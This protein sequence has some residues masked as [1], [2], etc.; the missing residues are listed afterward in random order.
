MRTTATSRFLFLVGLLCA[1]CPGPDFTPV[2]FPSAETGSR[3][4]APSESPR[5]V[6]CTVQFDARLCVAIKGE[7]V[8]VGTD[9]KDPL[10][11]DGLPP[12]PIEIDGGAVTIRG[13]RFPDLTIE[14]HGLPAPITINGRGDTSGSDNIGAGIIS[15]DGTIA[16]E[17]FS[18]FVMALGHSGKIPDLTLTTG[19][20]GPLGALPAVTGA[21][22]DSAGNLGLVTGTILGSLFPGADEV[23]K[24]AALTASFSGTVAPALSAC[25]ETGQ[26]AIFDATKLVVDQSGKEVG[27][28]LPGGNRLEVSAGTYIATEPTDV[29]PRFEATAKFRVVNN[30]DAPVPVQLTS[31]VGPFNIEAIG[32][33]NQTV[34]PNGE[35]IF[36]IR[37][38]PDQETVKKAGE[39]EQPLRIGPD[40]FLL[41]GTAIEPQGHP[42]IDWLAAD[43]SLVRENVDQVAVGE[44]IVAATTQHAYFQCAVALCGG[45][46]LPASCK[47]CADHAGGACQL[48]AVGAGGIPVDEVTPGCQPANPNEREQ[49]LINFGGDGVEPLVPTTQLLAIRNTGPKPLTVTQLVLKEAARSHSKGQFVFDPGRIFVGDRFDPAAVTNDSGAAQPQSAFPLVL[50]PFEPPFSATQLFV[51]VGYAPTDLV[52][53]EG[54]TAG[55]G[56]SVVDFAELNIITDGGNVSVKCKGTTRIKDMPPLQAVF[57]TATGPK[58][59]AD[60]QAFPFRG[61]TAATTDLPIP[62]FLRIPEGASPLRIIGIQIIGPDGAHFEWLDAKEE[63]LAKPEAARCT[64]LIPVSLAPNGYD[65]KP[66]AHT[67][68]TM[69]LFGCVNFHRGAGD[70]EQIKRRFQAMLTITAQPLGPDR[71]PLRNPD[72]TIK[73]SSLR[74]PLVAVINPR[75][76]PMV[77]RLTQTMAALMNQRFPSIAAVAAKGEVD[78]LIAAGQAKAEDRFLLL[79]SMFLD[80]F[81]EE[82]IMNESGETLSTP[83]DGITAVFRAIDTHPTSQDY[84]DPILSDFTNTLFNGTS[85]AGERGIFFDYPNVPSDLQVTALRLFTSSLSYPGPLATPEERPDQPSQCEVIDPCNTDK[86][87]RF[88]TGPA[89]QGKKGVC[90]FFFASGGAFA[91][92]AFRLPEAG[93]ERVDLCKASGPRK[94]LDWR[95]RYGLDGELTFEDGGLQFWGPTFVHNPFGPLG[96]VP[97]LDEVFHLAFTTETLLPTTETPG[98][99]LL[100]DARINI[101]KLEHKINLDDPTLE[102]PPLCRGNSKN[103]PFGGKRYSTWRYIAPF[104]SKDPRGESPAGCPEGGAAFTGGSAFVKGRRLDHASG[105]FS[106]AG[107]AKFSDRLELTSAFKDTMIFVVLNGWLC[108]PNGLPEEFEGARCYDRT[109][110]ERDARSQITIVEE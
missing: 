61:V 54:K 3:E 10:C 96:P 73:E 86:L 81:D 49:L 31:V 102:T 28:A 94:V 92:P 41:I 74:I 32:G 51:A 30:S 4:P 47:P 57:R 85:P 101:G 44:V 15:S 48:L 58:E 22:L 97:V 18:I 109:L 25:A 66:G 17:N 63:I 84:D 8:A 5:P 38:R 103:R 45:T 43:G 62:L 104:L 59:L 29:G 106:V 11:A 65:L 107:A 80:P 91:S 53:T 64:E 26:P 82:T 20:V 33:P 6:A 55:V 67:L 50:P 88:V 1:G 37:F 52:G 77:L 23:L 110:N 100:P 75:K 69:P 60:G 9:P 27:I 19:S 89:E 72:G 40:T 21:P 83:G 93:G 90:A 39:V 46:P 95:G 7:K 76:G 16:I 68:E 2:Y 34:A 70:G 13:D 99:Q 42:T 87:R 56:T 98:K 35:L 79:G 108:D 14:G 12:I 24:G 105:I 78:R 71:R 36:R